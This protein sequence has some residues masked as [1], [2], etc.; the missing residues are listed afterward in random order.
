MVEPGTAAVPGTAEKHGDNP[1]QRHTHLRPQVTGRHSQVTAGSFSHAV[2]RGRR[3]VDA[4][5]AVQR[6]RAGKG[7]G[8]R[9]GGLGAGAGAASSRARHLV[10][11]GQRVGEALALVQQENLGGQGIRVGRRQLQD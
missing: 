11:G 2:Q 5:Q 6:V 7:H 3:I 10:Q 4:A 1:D 9:Q 8:R